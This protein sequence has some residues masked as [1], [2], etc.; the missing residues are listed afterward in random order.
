[1]AKLIIVIGGEERE[2]ELEPL[3][4]TFESDQDDILNV[5]EGIVREEL[6]TD[7]KNENNDWI[8]KINKVEASQTVYVFPD[9]PAG[10]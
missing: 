8:V 3:G 9:S 4:L 2:L 5:V 6:G 1:M 7:L 10:S